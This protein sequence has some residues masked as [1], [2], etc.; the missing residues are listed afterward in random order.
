[1]FDAAMRFQT[2]LN[3]P[4]SRGSAASRASIAVPRASIGN[5]SLHA[6]SVEDTRTAYTLFSTASGVPPS[7]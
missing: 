5:G 3:A 1:M 4:A 6:H 2:E 7:S